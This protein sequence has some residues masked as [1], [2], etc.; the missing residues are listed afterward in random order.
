MSVEKNQPVS[1]L[2]ETRRRAKKIRNSLHVDEK[3]REVFLNQINHNHSLDVLAEVSADIC[4]KT[5]LQLRRNASKEKKLDTSLKENDISEV[6]FGSFSQSM[7]NK[8]TPLKSLFE[9]RPTR[10]NGANNKLCQRRTESKKKILL[11]E[12]VSV[13]NVLEDLHQEKRPIPEEENSDKAYF[14]ENQKP[15]LNQNSIPVFRLPLKAKNLI[16]NAKLKPHKELKPKKDLK[17]GL[18]LSTS[19]EANSPKE[20]LPR[21]KR[22]FSKESYQN[23]SCVGADSKPLKLLKSSALENT[24]KQSKDDISL[25]QGLKVTIQ[26]QKHSV[27]QKDTQMSKRTEKKEPIS[28]KDLL[29]SSAKLLKLKASSKTPK[30]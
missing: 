10:T 1:K 25:P 14:K 17:A 27:V 23:Y 16:Q 15:S 11:I 22:A 29:H 30:K 19:R 4:P 12:N 28:T 3:T 7:T 21:K 18:I 9:N 2:L 26:S 5:K 13:T 20:S 24:S 8:N 6:V